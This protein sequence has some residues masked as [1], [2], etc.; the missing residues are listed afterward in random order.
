VRFAQGRVDRIGIVGFA[1]SAGKAHLAGM[2]LQVRCALRQ[3]HA[4][5]AGAFHQRNEHRC[6]GR[7]AIVEAAAVTNEFGSPDRRPCEAFA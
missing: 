2:V 4:Q 3:Q 7:R 1:A 5:R 6:G